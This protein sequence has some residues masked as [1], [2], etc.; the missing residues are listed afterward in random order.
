MASAASLSAGEIRDFLREALPADRMAALERLARDN[1]D[2]MA[3]IAE[4]RDA[5]N[6]GD[7]SLGAIWQENQV[8]CPAREQLGTYLMQTGDPDYH[9]YVT[10]HLTVI[11]CPVCQANLDDLKAQAAAAKAK[12]ATGPKVRRRK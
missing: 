5:L 1:P 7:H 6:R 9:D 11:E 2:V 10:F 4:A 12:T 3:Q 8:S